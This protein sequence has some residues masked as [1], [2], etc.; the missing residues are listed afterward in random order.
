MKIL[1]FIDP[2]IYQNDGMFFAPHVNFV[3]CL[4]NANLSDDVHYALATSPWLLDEYQTLVS[5]HGGQ[6]D[7]ELLPLNPVSI[8]SGVGFETTAN[9]VDMFSPQPGNAAYRAL[10]TELRSR[11]EPDV[12]ICSTENPYIAEVFADRVVLYH[13]MSHIRR[14]DGTY[15]LYLDP[16]GHD[17]RN[18]LNACKAEILDQA[19]DDAV[20]S[21]LALEHQTALFGGVEAMQARL[22]FRDWRRQA[23]LEG[24]RIALVA[25]Q[26]VGPLLSVEGAWEGRSTAAFLT[27]S[28]AALPPGWKAVVSHHPADETLHRL[29]PYVAQCF[30]QS[31]QPPPEIF[32]KGSD[33]LVPEFDAIISISSKVGLLGVLCGKPV[34]SLG[35][36]GHHRYCGRRVEDLDQTEPL[37]PAAIGRLVRF[38]SN[39]YYFTF[40]E[41][42]TRPGFVFDLIRSIGAYPDPR[43][44][45]LDFS[46]WTPERLARLY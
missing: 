11:F 34:I 32:S 10:I 5:A 4:I 40:E 9:S 35:L 7:I 20:F 43:R 8:L 46:D 2:V 44:W 12:V 13:D 39:R 18:I 25:L 17:G 31:R 26:P 42:F 14:T 6:A 36:S 33:P 15:N 21:R 37:A 19:G 28:L 38:M 1:F 24:E 22:A 23:G 30:E 16:C 3:R 41:L 27:H 45:Q 29:A